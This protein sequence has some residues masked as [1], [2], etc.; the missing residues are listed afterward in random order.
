MLV[1]YV[2]QRYKFFQSL[3]SKVRNKCIDKSLP[4]AVWI[5]GGAGVPSYWYELVF[6]FQKLFTLFFQAVIES[7]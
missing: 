1:R 3:G 6:S 4:T 2:G 5:K 7:G